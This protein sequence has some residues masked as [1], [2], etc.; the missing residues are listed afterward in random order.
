MPNIGILIQFTVSKPTDLHFASLT[1][2][3]NMD[4]NRG[5][6]NFDEILLPAE[7]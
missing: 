2:V 1:V 5:Q 7:R 3:N 6:S 4:I